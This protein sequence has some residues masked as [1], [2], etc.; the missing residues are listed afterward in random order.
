V[1]FFLP[2]IF[3]MHKMKISFLFLALAIA[4]NSCKDST[5]TDKALSQKVDSLEAKV[6]ELQKLNA[7]KPSPIADTTDVLV[8]IEEPKIS[9]PIPSKTE[10]QPK[11]ITEKVEKEV[12]TKYPTRT[13]DTLF[14]YYTGSGKV[15]AFISPWK[16]NRRSL[17]L[18]DPFGKETYRFDDYQGGFSSVAKIKAFHPNGAVS[19]VHH[20]LNPGASI[21][22]YASDYTFGINNEPLWKVDQEFPQTLENSMNNQSYWDANSHTWKKQEVSIE[23]VIPQN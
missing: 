18:F 2:Y 16:D 3:K 21:N 5:N 4:M 13:E 11:K 7:A 19:D 23:T 8:N 10:Q 14:Y 12:V 9:N 17:V 6:A 1:A 15:S 22:W 20:Y